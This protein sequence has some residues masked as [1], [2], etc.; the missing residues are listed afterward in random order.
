MFIQCHFDVH[1]LGIWEGRETTEMFWPIGVESIHVSYSIIFTV[2]YVNF[3]T[4]S[5]SICIGTPWLMFLLVIYFWI[6][7]EHFK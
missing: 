3:L 2:I 7:F 5:F 6:P 4:G 1:V